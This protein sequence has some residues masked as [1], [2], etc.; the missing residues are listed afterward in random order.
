MLLICTQPNL[1][2]LKKRVMAELPTTR[3]GDSPFKSSHVTE[4]IAAALGFSTNAALK[5]GMASHG[6]VW[7]MLRRLDGDAFVAR[8]AKLV[9]FLRGADEPNLF[10]GGGLEISAAFEFAWI[11]FGYSPPAY[12]ASHGCAHPLL[13]PENHWEGR[14]AAVAA[15]LGRA[16]ERHR[17][18][19]DTLHVSIRHEGGTDFSC[20]VSDKPNVGWFQ[21]PWT[22]GGGHEILSG[23]MQGQGSGIRAF[24][25]LLDWER[26]PAY[27][28]E[29]VE[30]IDA[31]YGPPAV[32]LPPGE[33]GVGVE[34]WPRLVRY[35]HHIDGLPQPRE[36]CAIGAAQFEAIQAAI[37]F[38]VAR[39]WD[40][41]AA[42]LQVVP[43]RWRQHTPG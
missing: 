35:S 1:D 27:V 36:A 29:E 4:A 18:E 13:V 9:P 10:F 2:L 16:Y 40:P 8:I 15:A 6:G 23:V 38:A 42:A 5:T 17:N 31:S 21:F 43:S 7:P 12:A 41:V 14:L 19:A 11:S 37:P 34:V 20:E 33:L 22:R 24:A 28:E 25:E 30:A 3:R 32:S 39:G 26:I